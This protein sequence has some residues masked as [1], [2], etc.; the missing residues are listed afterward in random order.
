MPRFLLASGLSVVLLALLSCRVRAE[1]PVP[2][3]E[4]LSDF[5]LLPEKSRYVSH[6]EK[7][8]AAIDAK[9][10]PV[11]ATLLQKLL[12]LRE[13]SLVPLTPKSAGSKEE[14]ILVS[15]RGEAEAMLAA[16]P[17]AG[18]KAYQEEYGA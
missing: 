8:R 14:K 5:T 18:R 6:L 10:W 17:L 11:A 2:K 1:Q 9:D 7:A 12:D 15:L 13:D 16:L 4:P 3:N